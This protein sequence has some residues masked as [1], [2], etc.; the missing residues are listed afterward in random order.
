MCTNVCTKV[1]AHT[2]VGVSVIL[3]PPTGVAH[4]HAVVHAR[5][6]Q[7]IAVVSWALNECL[8]T[9]TQP[10]TRQQRFCAAYILGFDSRIERTSFQ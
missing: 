2:V 5:R 6:H 3:L 1:C 10:N 7:H 4:A 8:T 9:S